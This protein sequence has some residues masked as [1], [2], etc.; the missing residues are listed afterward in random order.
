MTT[1]DGRVAAPPRSWWIEQAFERLG[2][3]RGEHLIA[4][5]PRAPVGKFGRQALQFGERASAVERIRGQRR[6]ERLRTR[7]QR[8][9]GEH[10]RNQE[11]H[12]S[13]AV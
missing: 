6:D 10:Q 13:R 12:E 1:V 8:E 11:R 9:R 7:G 2:D 5:A 4:L 3:V